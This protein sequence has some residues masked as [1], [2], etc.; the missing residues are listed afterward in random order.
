MSEGR[1]IK[2]RL[3]LAP[4]LA[5]LRTKLYE[6]Q[7]MQ[8]EDTSLA[9]VQQL[10]DEITIISE[11]KINPAYVRWGLHS[12][13]GLTI[14]DTPATVESLIE[15]GPR[16]LYNEIL[17]AIKKESG[18]DER[19]QGESEPLTTSGAQVDGRKT[20]TSAEAAADPAII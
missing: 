20:S 15:S 19:Q 3:A 8:K 16:D 14:D 6:A 11:D 4:E 17:D 18:L 13:E 5:V 10:G 7:S 2:L 1:R 9:V 12:I